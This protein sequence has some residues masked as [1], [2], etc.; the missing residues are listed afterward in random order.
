MAEIFSTFFLPMSLL[1][2]ARGMVGKEGNND[3]PLGGTDNRAVAPWS[4]LAPLPPLHAYTSDHYTL[5]PPAVPNPIEQRF[6]LN[7][8]NTGIIFVLLN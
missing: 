4:S 7:H 1:E 5:P 8:I 3:V 2:V 6:S